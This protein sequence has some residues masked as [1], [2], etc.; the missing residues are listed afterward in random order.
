LSITSVRNDVAHVIKLVTNWSPLRTV[1]IRIK[2]FIVRAIGQIIISEELYHVQNI[3]K[4]L[5]WLI[6]S[7]TD[8]TLSNG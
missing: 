7:K 1:Y 4:H 5:F 8:G 2:D 3:L 6:Y